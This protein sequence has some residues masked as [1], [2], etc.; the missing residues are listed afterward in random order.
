MSHRQD[1][2]AETPT[3]VASS[4]RRRGSII[5]IDPGPL[6]L[7]SLAGV[8]DSRGFTCVCGR[9][10]ADAV[11][12]FQLGP[13][14]LIVWDIADDAESVLRSL[15]DIRQQTDYRHFPAVLLAE[16]RWAGLEKRL[17]SCSLTRCLFKPIDHRVLTS[18]VENLLWMPTL[19]EAHRRRGSR[20]SRPGWVGL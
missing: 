9:T 6:S 2:P 5:V 17:E 20:P 10:A 8:L 14:D 3:A 12:A 13:Q 4:S 7:L 19:L 11:G 16:T 15:D 18:L 1:P